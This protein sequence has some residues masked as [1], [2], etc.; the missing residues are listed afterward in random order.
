MQ[1]VLAGRRG[2]PLFI[3]DIA[4]PRDVEPAVNTLDGVYL[5]DIDDLQQVVDANL[6]ERKR[7]AE[8]AGRQIEEEVAAFERWLQSLEVTPTIVSLRR[9]FQE[10]GEKEIERQRRRLADLSEEQRHAVEELT[11]AVV[12]KL[13]HAPLRHLREAASAGQATSAAWTSG[14]AKI[15]R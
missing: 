10:V 5:Y 3:I 8:A 1:R 13:L 4:V 14:R 15:S 6:E 2:R 9:S 7:A 11:R 12:N